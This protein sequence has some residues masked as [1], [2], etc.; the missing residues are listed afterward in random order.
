MG[1][2]MGPDDHI[3]IGQLGAGENRQSGFSMMI[4]IRNGNYLGRYRQLLSKFPRLFIDYTDSF[5]RNTD[6]LFPQHY[7]YRDLAFVSLNKK[8]NWFHYRMRTYKDYFNPEENTSTK[9]IMLGKK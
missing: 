4:G 9:S 7:V 2:E 1:I 5:V 3:F 6:G 8:D